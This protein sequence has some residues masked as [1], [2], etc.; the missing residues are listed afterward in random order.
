MALG[1]PLIIPASTLFARL[2]LDGA[3]GFFHDIFAGAQD[4]SIQFLQIYVCEANATDAHPCLVAL[5]SIP[6]FSQM[7]TTTAHLRLCVLAPSVSTPQGMFNCLGVKPVVPCTLTLRRKRQMLHEAPSFVKFSSVQNRSM[8]RRSNSAVVRMSSFN[9]LRDQCFR[10]QRSSR[11]KRQG[12]DRH[13][14]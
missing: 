5:L 11:S 4:S 10:D 3:T 13:V 12:R 9:T 2:P 1:P 14:E 6:T 7:W 8:R